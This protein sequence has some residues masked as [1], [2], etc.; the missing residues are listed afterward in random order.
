MVNFYDVKISMFVACKAQICSE[1]QPGSLFHTFT[2]KGNSV[3]LW[4]RQ[5]RSCNEAGTD[6]SISAAR[7]CESF[8]EESTMHNGE[9]KALPRS[10]AARQAGARPWKAA[11]GSQGSPEGERLEPVLGEKDWDLAPVPSQAAPGMS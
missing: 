8:P 3:F 7:S 11:L 1:P 2:F 10:P 5:P 6:M 9:V 4:K